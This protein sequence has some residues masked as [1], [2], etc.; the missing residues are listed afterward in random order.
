VVAEG[1]R[2]PVERLAAALRDRRMLL[3]VDNFEH[4]VGAAPELVTLLRACPAL[5]I[6]TTSRR[7]LRVSGEREVPLA[8]LPTPGPDGTF[9]VDELAE[10]P[11]VALFLARAKAAKHDFALTE[12]NAAA[13]ATVCSRLD[14]L[15]LALELAAAR[16]KVLSPQALAS[17]LSGRLA[18]LTTGARDLPARQQTLRDAIAWS[19]DLLTPEEKALFCRLAVFSGGATLDAIEAVA[20]E[21]VGDP[22]ETVATLVDHSLL[23]REG[24][25]EGGEPRLRMLETIREFALEQL[26]ASGDE[27]A[28]RDAHARYYVEFAAHSAKP[29]YSTE[30]AVQIRRLSPD[31]GN[32][33]A[34]LSWLLDGQPFGSERARLGLRLAG[35]MGRFWETRGYLREG[36]R[37]MTRALANVPDEPTPERG[38]AL[39]AL[40]VNAWFGGELDLARERQE[41]ALAIWRALDARA[42]IVRSLWIIGLVA[43]K[44]GDVAKLEALAAEAAPFAPEIG[45]TLW[46]KVP[47]SLLALAALTRGDGAEARALFEPTLAYHERHHFDWAHAWVLGVLAEA[48]HLDGERALAL[49]YYQRSLLQFHQHGDIYATTDGLLAVSAHAALAGQEETAARL[50]GVVAATR[51]VI[52]SRT[53]WRTIPEDEV[54]RAAREA[55][56][57][58]AF[59]AAR[60]A[61]R[62]LTLDEAVELALAV[63]AESDYSPERPIETDYGLSARELDVLRLV[64]EGKSNQEI[65]EALSISPRTVGAHLGNIFGK[66]GVNSRAAAT[67][68]A[69]QQ[70]LV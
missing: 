43:A 48:A 45:I 26:R 63:T 3:V 29:E 59:E 8:P 14:G 67:S 33:Q 9:D 28:A 53:T 52:G 5:S 34:A 36:A 66:L 51:E 23:V 12:A 24:A 19:F 49:D 70:G 44:R 39:T 17:R 31:L 18:L 7:V 57:D 41:R 13:V 6:L 50:L 2:A 47:E 32:I 40:G 20:G 1:G 54:E 30:E 46:Q 35:A 25:A 68:L 15:P 38:I 21:R 22:F 69:Y 61:G 11:A 37:W 58:T 62:A 60:A 42:A 10:L 65:G 4:L 64:A 55:L 16:V 27:E 56:G